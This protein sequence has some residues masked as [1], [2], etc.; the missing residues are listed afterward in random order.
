MKDFATGWS[1]DCFSYVSELHNSSFGATLRTIAN[2]F[3]LISCPR[4]K[5]N[6]KKIEYKGEEIEESKTAAIQVQIQ[7][8]TETELK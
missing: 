2:D 8:F 1:G 3:D 5:K 6:V 4:L 7:D